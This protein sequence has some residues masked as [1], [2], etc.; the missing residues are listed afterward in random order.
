MKKTALFLFAMVIALSSTAQ[1]LTKEEKQK[2]KE[3]KKILLFQI[4]SK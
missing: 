3:K 1:G 2:I 4:K